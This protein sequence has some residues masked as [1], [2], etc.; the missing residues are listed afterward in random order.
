FRQEGKVDGGRLK[1]AHFL[2]RGVVSDFSQIGG[3]SFFAFVRNL[4][5]RSMGNR[6]RVAMTL[7]V[8]NVESGEIVGS[9]RCS[10]MTYTSRA[11]LK[12]RYK[13]VDFGGDTFMRTPLGTATT[14]AIRRGVRGVVKTVPITYWQPM[15]A[16]VMGTRI[17]LNGGKDRGITVGREF[18]VRGEGRTV[19]DPATGDVLSVI[20]GP[21]LG[22]VRVTQV[23][24]KISYAEIVRGR[25][26][27]RGQR[28]V[29]IK[30]KSD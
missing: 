7:T 10:G 2:I 17:V 20:P 12:S 29:G 19:T 15:I 3:G 21:A 28:L 16:D 4:F 26:L 30:H 18:G 14:K 27:Q 22:H 25:G 13:N 23:L 1:N 24:D 6:A 8:V 5:I 9:A 11:F